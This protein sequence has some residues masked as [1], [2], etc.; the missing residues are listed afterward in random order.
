MLN[1]PALV[2]LCI[3]IYLSAVLFFG[4]FR[5]ILFIRENKLIDH[6][7]STGDIWYAFL[8]GLRF[9]LVVTGYIMAIPFVILATL[10]FF[11]KEQR[12]LNRFV[13]YL[14]AISFSIAFVVCAADIPYFNQ[15]FSRLSI[16]AFEWLDNPVFIFKM[17]AQEPRYWLIILPLILVLYL[18]IKLLKKI[19]ASFSF[20]QQ[21]RGNIYAKI[22]Y[23]IIGAGLIFLGIRGRID[24]KSPIKTGTAYF[25]NNA[26]LNQLGLNPNFTLIKS[27]LENSDEENNSIRLMDDSVAIKNVQQY[28]NISDADSQ[29]P[30]RRDILFDS[31]ATRYNVVLVLMESM[32]TAKMKRHGNT[33]NLTPFFDSLSYQGYYF[34]NAYSA[35]IHTHNG[36]FSSLFS[37]PALF[38]QHSMKESAIIKF[39]G[40]YSTLKKNGYSTIYFTTHDGQFDNVE[41][42]LKANDCE[43]FISKPDY[44]SDKVKTTLGVPDDYM[45]EFSMP[46][47]N[48]LSNKNKPFFATFMTASDHG[49]FYVPDYFTPK[50]KDKRIAVTEFADYSLRRLIELASKQTWFSNTIFVFVA[51]HGAPIDVVYDMPVNYNHVPLLFY[52]PGIIKEKKTFD[53]MAG[54]IDIFPTIMGMLKIPYE[55]NTLGINLFKEKRPYIYCNGDDKYG[56]LNKDWFLI[57][58]T[59]QAKGLY[60][61]RSRDKKN[62]AGLYPAV[63]DSMDIYAK[64]NLQT[65]QHILNTKSH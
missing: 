38:R 43:Q 46:K 3:K 55:N 56:V 63:A 20:N 22:T 34:E 65:Y 13:F 58:G 51:D 8:M 25:S 9:D 54:Q 39:P 16:T 45:F 31:A 64:S 41:G 2:R 59:D 1:I 61:Y 10:S 19:F 62:Y 52:A 36:I 27:Y 57:V 49:P 7:V 5:V 37:Y 23:Y 35:G 17:V 50:H 12:Y 14:M 44:P 32:A 33:E 42:F 28:L 60:K 30:L 29:F 18:F 40:I 4:L 21:E 11:K 48:E 26:F 53:A 15:F 6:S 47:L 24:E